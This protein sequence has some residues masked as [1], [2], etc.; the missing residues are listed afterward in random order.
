VLCSG[1]R[2]PEIAVRLKYAGVDESLIEVEPSIERALDSAVAGSAAGP[3]FALP[4]Y[5]ALIELRT[6]LASRG[7]AEEFWR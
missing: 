7:L 2:A 1:T 3:V 5:T 4:T 6:L